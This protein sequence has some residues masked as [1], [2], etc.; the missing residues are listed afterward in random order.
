[1]DIDGKSRSRTK[2]RSL[3]GSPMDIDPK[4]KSKSASRP[5]P[6]TMDKAIKLY[7]QVINRAFGDKP[8]LNR[9]D[10]LLHFH[11]DKMPA[12]LNQFATHNSA[13]QSFVNHMFDDLLARK[14]AID[15]QEF[16]VVLKKHAKANILN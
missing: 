8:A 1:M 9:R 14:H 2:T 15:R 3:L 11:P 16:M 13:F 12:P 7:D 6:M 5:S 10:V 4:S